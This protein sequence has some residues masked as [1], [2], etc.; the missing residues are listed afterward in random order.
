MYNIFMNG[1]VIKIFSDFYYVETDLGITEC[2]LRTVLKKQNIDVCTGDYVELEQF[3][4]NSM[5]AFISAVI[6]RKSLITRPKVA[7]VTQETI[8]AYESGKAY[9]SVETLIKIAEFLNTSTDFK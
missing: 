9:P 4:K 8:S 1:R 3:E 7:N 5:Q 2:K 6:N